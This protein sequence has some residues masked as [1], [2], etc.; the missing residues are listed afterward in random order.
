MKPTS[1][2]VREVSVSD[3]DAWWELWEGYNSFYDASVAPEISERTW[4]RII[5]PEAPFVGR[6]AEY[7][8][9]IVG[10]SISVLHEGTWT[11]QPILYLEDLFVDP[12]ARGSGIGRALM[13]D[14]IA[15]AKARGCSRLYWHTQ[16]DNTVARC[17]YDAFLPADDFVRYRLML[18]GAREQ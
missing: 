10:L 4:E 8:G 13:N 3:R 7:G 17:L 6:L 5:D 11:A 18:D 16:A 2:N 9:R 14:V 12:A 15:Q 1:M